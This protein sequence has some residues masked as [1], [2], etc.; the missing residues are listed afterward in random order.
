MKARIFCLCLVPLL[1]SCVTLARGPRGEWKHLGK[2]SVLDEELSYSLSTAPLSEEERR[3]IYESVNSRTTYGSL[4][5][6]GRNHERQEALSA[7]VWWIVLAEDESKQVVVQ[8]TA[9]FCGA[10]GNCTIW[11][12]AP[13]N[14]RLRLVL[15]TGGGIF[16]VEKTSHRG[17]HDVA[18]GWHNS[19][20]Q[21]RSKVYQWAGSRYTQSDCYDGLFNAADRERT[22]DIQDCPGKPPRT[23]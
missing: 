22:P 6:A 12:F 15:K 20:E 16:I 3:Q 8:G 7:R 2:D 17:F 14:G 19:A 4:T 5:A 23:N 11:I 18:I 9:S 21:E 1:F 13:R 10:S